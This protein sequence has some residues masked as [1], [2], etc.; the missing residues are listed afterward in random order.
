MF[1]NLFF[2]KGTY[3]STTICLDCEKESI[4]CEQFVCLSLPIPL[5]NECT[6]EDCLAYL[7]EEEYLPDDSKYF[8][9]SKIA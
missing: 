3:Q 5:K 7:N 6:L 4:S 9:M 1:L 8:C 2:N